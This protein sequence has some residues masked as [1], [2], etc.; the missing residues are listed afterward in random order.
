MR[1]LF[2]NRKAELTKLEN[3]LTLGKDYVL[4]APRR[5]GKTALARMV[6]KKLNITS[7]N[8]FI[9]IDLMSYSSGSVASVAECIIEKV[10]NSL[11]FIGKLRMILKSMEFTFNLRMKYQDLE[12]EP[13]LQ[14]FKSN[15]EWALLEEALDLAEKVAIKEKKRLIVF[16]DEF[17]ELS[18]LNKRVI[19]LFRSVIQNHE[20]VSYLFA[21]SQESL[22][23]EIFLDKSGAFYRFGEII[24]LKELNR[25]D[26]LIYLEQNFPEIGNSLNGMRDLR[27]INIILETLKGHPY[28]TAQAIAYFE[29]N[30][31]CTYE[32]FHEFLVTD[33]FE[34]ERPLLEQQLLN[35]S[36][37][38]HAID[39]LRVISLGINPYGTINA[40][41]NAHIYNVLQYLSNAGYIRK[42]S[43]GV[44][45][46]TDPLMSLLLNSI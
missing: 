12:I 20:N 19:E 26:L 34:R 41:S 5:Y 11:G 44:Y 1:N 29:E 9:H 8:C 14:L 15:D 23:T 35:I 45:Q 17:A 13:M 38:Q 33:L 4:I 24:Y 40:I 3:G 28:Y 16:F 31:T 37:K 10:L 18:K 6:G 43:R 7:P 32:Q 36:E 27:V 42:L 46:L 22:M 21:G 30:P 25:E 39:V 2:I